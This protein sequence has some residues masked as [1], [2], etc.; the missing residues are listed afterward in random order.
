MYR[1]PYSDKWEEKDWD[2]TLN[3]IA[4]RVKEARDR[5]IILQNAAGKTVN[6]FESFQMGHRMPPMRN[7]L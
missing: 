7:V 3:Q 4:R 6:R 1:A 2:W 5:D